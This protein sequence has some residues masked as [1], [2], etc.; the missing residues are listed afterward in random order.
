MTDLF[1]FSVDELSDGTHST[2]KR[3]QSPAGSPLSQEIELLNPVSIPEPPK[4]LEQELFGD[5]E[6][7]AENSPVSAQLPTMMDLSTT[8][9][10]I[11]FLPSDDEGLKDGDH[12][13]VSVMQHEKAGLDSV[14]TLILDPQENICKDSPVDS[15]E[16]SDDESQTKKLIRYNR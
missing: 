1:G 10:G 12:L 11:M 15:R 2:P 5:V 7:F 14:E 8:S 4:I 9:P 6:T 16:S 13:E 3:G